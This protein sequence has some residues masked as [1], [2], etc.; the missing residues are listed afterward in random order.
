L[1]LLIYNKPGGYFLILGAHS[2]KQ[3]SYVVI[4]NLKSE[5]ACKHLSY[6][7]EISIWNI[8]ISCWQY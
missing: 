7:L 3:S 2:M 8:Y 1:W 4:L 6:V 5:A